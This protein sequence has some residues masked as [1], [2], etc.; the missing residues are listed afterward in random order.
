M[1]AW[2]LLADAIAKRVPVRFTY[3]GVRR[4]ACPHKLGYDRSSRA[5][6]LVCQTGGDGLGGGG[7]DDDWRCLF[8]D[9]LR[10]VEIIEGRFQTPSNYSAAVPNCMASVAREVPGGRIPLT[11]ARKPKAARRRR[12]KRPIRWKRK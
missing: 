12:A 2:S 6:V 9:L 4:V 7:S 1:N 5:K 3:R 8:V 11:G 10:E